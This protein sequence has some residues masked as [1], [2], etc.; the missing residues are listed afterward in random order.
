[1]SKHKT[2]F[3]ICPIVRFFCIRESEISAISIN[4]D[5][6]IIKYRQLSTLFEDHIINKKEAVY[7]KIVVMNNIRSLRILLLFIISNYP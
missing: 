5:S 3:I 1:M 4:S 2:I 6:A 7:L